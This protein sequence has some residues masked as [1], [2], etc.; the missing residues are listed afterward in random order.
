MEIWKDARAINSRLIELRHDLHRHPE[1][2]LKLPV[3]TGKIKAMLE[4]LDIPCEEITSSAIRA[5]IGKPGGRRI[6]LRGDMD[7][8][9]IEENSGVP[10]RS[11]EPGRMHA[12]GHD[13]HTA[14]LM[15]AAMI[16]K[17]NE[18]D[19]DGQVILMF[20]PGEETADGARSMIE[21]GIL[22]PAPDHAVAIHIGAT[23]LYDT[24][25]VV[26]PDQDV[27]ASRDEFT[28]TVSGI[29]GHGAEPHR[30]RNP[31]LAAVKMVEAL[32]DLARFEVDAASPAVLTVCQIQ[33]GSASNI[34]PEQCT[35]RGTLRMTDQETRER[36]RQRMAAIAAGIAS[37][38][39]VEASLRFDGALP[40]L[41]NDRVFTEQIHQWLAAGLPE[42][43]V[44]PP[45]RYFSMGSDDFALISGQ[46]PSAYLIVLSRSPIGQH[47]PEHH[48]SVS[49]DDDA[50]AVG[51][52]VFALIALRAVQ[53][54]ADERHTVGGTM[55]AS[56]Q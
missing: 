18:P 25:I 31:I 2:G 54:P 32:T 35:F 47:F 28:V 9:P 12:C 7:A 10:Y 3:T 22:E 23:D 50:I 14:M 15:G 19:L 38:Y 26:I 17:Q 39:G 41:A 43:Q 55:T 8:L 34:I 56:D 27:Y 52:A 49:F 1:L 13:L 16:L 24:G 6:L 29:G 45:G 37:A 53:A 42:I 11:L 48:E 33:A 40:M 46:V 4:S 36:V 21:A 44:A 20:Q 30:S 51:A 5:T